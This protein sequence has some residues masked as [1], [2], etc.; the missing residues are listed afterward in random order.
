MMS[1]KRDREYVSLFLLALEYKFLNFRIP[2]P[3]FHH[4]VEE[5]INADILLTRGQ[6]REF[7]GLY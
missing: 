7:C 2:F 5:K 1:V 4:T 6:H 3:G